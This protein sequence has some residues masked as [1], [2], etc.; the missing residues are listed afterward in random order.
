MRVQRGMIF[1]NMGTM[2]PWFSKLIDD[3]R[4]GR[5]VAVRHRSKSEGG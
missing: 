5:L 4:V 1:N 3:R 2:V